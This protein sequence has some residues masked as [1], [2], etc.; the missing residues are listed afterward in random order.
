VT[1]VLGRVVRDVEQL[2]VLSHHHEEATESLQK[3]SQTSAL[4][5]MHVQIFTLFSSLQSVPLQNSTNATIKSFK[6]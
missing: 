3:D 1:Q 4:R 2:A 6:I 5:E